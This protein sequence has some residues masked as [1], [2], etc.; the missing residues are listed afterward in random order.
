[1]KTETSPL[2]R[3][4]LFADLPPETLSRV[5]TVLIRRTYAPDETIVLEGAPCQAAYFLARG[6]VRVLRTSP[7]GRE[8]VLVQLGPGQSFNT[9]PPFRTQGT[10][11]ATVQAADQVTVYAISRD[12]LH[13]L[14]SES[15]ALALA[16]LRD[17]AD[18]LDHLTDLVEDLS[19]RTV[20][21]RLARLLLEEATAD[22]VARRWTQAEIAARLGTVREMIG[23][24]LSALAD[25]G[26]IRIDRQRIV[27]LDR[28]G[29][30]AE[31]S[32]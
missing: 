30:E 21:G 5:A 9:V 31:A 26:L 6:H 24:T 29:L 7:D 10:N 13:R 2:R 28:Q 18:R 1:M 4:T 17:F 27:L 8:Q 32:R 16:L 11:H 14:V 23:R 3:I 22:E 20:R 15:P 12:D 25:A 19:L